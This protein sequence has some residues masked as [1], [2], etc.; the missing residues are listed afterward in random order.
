[1]ALTDDQRAMLR[2]LARREEGYEDIAA[3]M[4]ISV[5]EV[6]ARVRDSLAALDAETTLDAAPTPPP[7][8][9]QPPEPAAEPRQEVAPSAPPQAS[10]PTPQ[11]AAATA[12]PAGA[13]KPSF[14]A[15]AGA[16]VGRVRKGERRR[17]V[18]LVGGGLIVLLIALFATGTINL[19]GDD[20]GNGNGDNGTQAVADGN[21]EPTQAELSAV[22][23]SDAEGQAVFGRFKQQVALVIA[24]EGMRPTPKGRSYAISLAKGPD[25]RVPIAAVQVGDNGQL[26]EQIEVPPEA[27]GLLANG[28]DTMELS[29]VVNKDLRR[30]LTQ[31]QGAQKPPVFKATDV[32]RGEVT[33]PIVEAGTG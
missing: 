17:L 12:S 15:R 16:W 1:M 33:G 30:I 21:Q 27:L 4:G 23:G 24:A 13:G 20:D 2:L 19:G 5:E 8:P 6:R 25:E 10:A 14:A 11:P 18:E 3:L 9:V 28:F 22:D 26:A 31:S 32:L 29:L 7:A